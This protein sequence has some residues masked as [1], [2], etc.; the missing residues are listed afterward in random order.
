MSFLTRPPEGRSF[1]ATF[2]SACKSFRIRLDFLLVGFHIL[3]CQQHRAPRQTFTRLPSVNPQF[4]R[5]L[6]VPAFPHLISKWQSRV[7]FK[8]YPRIEHNHTPE[9]FFCRISPPPLHCS[10][11]PL[12]LCP[13]TDLLL[14]CTW[15]VHAFLIWQIRSNRG[16]GK[17]QSVCS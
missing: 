16:F 13:N 9:V 8:S 7:G 17:F 14:F 4:F 6:A 10:V 12:P 11:S 2:L 1:C 3:P 15:E 5:V